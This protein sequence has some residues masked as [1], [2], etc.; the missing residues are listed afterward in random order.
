MTID[1]STPAM[2]PTIN[3]VNRGIDRQSAKGLYRYSIEAT[4]M[5]VPACPLFD[6]RAR[7]TAGGARR[8]E[9]GWNRLHTN[10]ANETND[11]NCSVPR[12]PSRRREDG[13]LLN[14]LGCFAIEASRGRS[15]KHSAPV[16]GG[17]PLTGPFVSFVSFVSFVT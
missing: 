9:H 1:A 11:A 13:S 8:A 17:V 6:G 7:Y 12:T 4:A 15:I 3:Q 2:S 10:D 16:L 5:H 14:D